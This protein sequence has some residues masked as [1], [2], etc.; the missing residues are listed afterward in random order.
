MVARK[1]SLI[2]LASFLACL[3]LLGNVTPGLS[4]DAKQAA[5]VQELKQ[6]NVNKASAEELVT[7][8]GIGPVIAKRIIDYRAANG[9]FKSLEELAQVNGIGKAKYEKMKEQ[10]SL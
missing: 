2:V 4:K 9:A 5:S 10:L 8:R 3:F 6:V 7:V 1:K